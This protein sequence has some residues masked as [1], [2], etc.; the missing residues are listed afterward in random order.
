MAALTTIW[1]GYLPLRKSLSS[2][3]KPCPSDALVNNAYDELVIRIVKAG[4][5]FIEA[6]RGTLG[7]ETHIYR[8]VA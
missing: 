8:L 1:S 2:H 7:S 4:R 5:H 3:N 6:V